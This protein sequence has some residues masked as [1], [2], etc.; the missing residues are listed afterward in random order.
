MPRCLNSW[1]EHLL[2]ILCERSMAAPF[3]F[4]PDHISQGSHRKQREPADLVWACNNCVI[5]MYMT[6]SDCSAESAA[7]HNLGQAKGWLK[8]WKH[9]KI[10]SGSNAWHKFSISYGKATHVIVLSV[11]HHRGAVI[12]HDD[13]AK[14]LGVVCCA[15]IPDVVIERLVTM[16]GS[17]FDLVWELRIMRE[18]SPAIP[19]PESKALAFLGNHLKDCQQLLKFDSAWPGEKTSERWR[20]AADPILDLKHR[21]MIKAVSFPP[22]PELLPRLSVDMDGLNDVLND[23]ILADFYKL[24]VTL[25]MGIDLVQEQ[26][27]KAEPLRPVSTI[28]KLLY[29]DCGVFVTPNRED[30][31]DTYKHLDDHYFHWCNWYGKAEKG[32]IRYGP[33]ISYE[34]RRG[35]SMMCIK[36][37]QIPSAIEDF[38]TKWWHRPIRPRELPSK[39]LIAGQE[40]SVLTFEI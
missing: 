36:Q 5:L 23:M 39:H 35:A 3:V 10:L 33:L 2:A 16:G 12:F 19:I 30:V 38:L 29:Y 25:R 31:P 40:F 13:A 7:T 37:R 34:L 9:G 15:T 26:I 6:A 28:A 1:Q 24:V 8:L 27:R 32:S 17:A 18:V 11:I 20:E 21:G 14:S 22:S 4:A